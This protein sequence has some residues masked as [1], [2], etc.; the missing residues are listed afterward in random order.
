MGRN[1]ENGGRTR[2]AQ[3]HVLSA[4]GIG[5]VAGRRPGARTQPSPGAAAAAAI[6]AS[7]RRSAAVPRA[8]VLAV[9]A[10]LA[11]LA[12]LVALGAAVAL[13]G[14]DPGTTNRI[15]SFAALVGPADAVGKIQSTVA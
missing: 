11:M 10:A 4:P 15:L 12:G 3:A 9:H 7:L 1:I 6:A 14:D 13:I 2:A 8:A 5:A